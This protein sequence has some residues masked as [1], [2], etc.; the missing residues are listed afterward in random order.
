MSNE[1]QKNPVPI[2]N[3]PSNSNKSRKDQTHKPSVSE[4]KTTKNVE[5]VVTGEAKQRKIPLSRKIKET[6]SGEDMHSVGSYI[7]FEV[8]LPQVKTMISDAASQGVERMLFGDVVSRSSSRSSGRQGYTNYNKVSSNSTGRRD[9]RA[10][11][12]RARA[13]HDFGEVI[14][15]SRGEAEQV[16]ERLMDLVDQ[17]EVATVSDLYDLVGITGSFTDD[18]WGWADL[19]GARVQRQRNDYLLNLPRPEPID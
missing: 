7:L 2:V 1:E 6:F 3:Y 4:S 8:F 17:Y 14:L 5:K 11:S 13:N 15:Q 18:K 19:R 12:H 10:L 9:E 16:L